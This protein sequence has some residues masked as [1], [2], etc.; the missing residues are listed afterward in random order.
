MVTPV[1]KYEENKSVFGARDLA[2]NIWEWTKDWDRI[3]IDMKI[4]RGGSWADPPQFL[5]CDRHLYANPK[6]KFDNIGFRCIRP[7]E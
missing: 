4:I 5:R 2:G 1:E 7:A 3:E 6:D